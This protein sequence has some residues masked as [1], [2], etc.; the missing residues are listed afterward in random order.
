M[1]SLRESIKIVDF[2]LGSS[3]L[4]R[5][6][7]NSG[8]IP[9][10][11]LKSPRIPY[12]RGSFVP[13]DTWRKPSNQERKKI[14]SEH[15]LG[16]FSKSIGII[17]LPMHVIRP[18]QNAVLSLNTV[19][20]DELNNLMSPILDHLKSYEIYVGYNSTMS[21][22][23]SNPPNLSTVTFNGAEKC[24]IGLHLDS[25]DRMPLAKRAQST[26][27]ICI[28]I[29]QEDRYLLFINL[30]LMDMLEILRS[31]S[32]SLFE[33][34]RIKQ[35]IENMLGKKLIESKFTESMNPYHVGPLFMDSYSSYPVI[36]IRVSPGE[37]YIAPTENMI[38]DGSTLGKTF[39]D[40]HLTIRGYFWPKPLD[41]PEIDSS[42]A[43]DWSF[44]M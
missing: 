35:L 34:S 15:Y 29:G 8:V 5:F 31:K 36:K 1:L 39:L 26:N 17:R 37:A 16:D 11:K 13:K 23:A 20:S 24:Y 38:H 33:F 28:N 12:K 30:T 2:S 6:W 7:I 43:E 21:G 19:Q 10:S 18:L 14:F 25:W 32:R 4:P 22:I 9:C 41:C 42:N 3:E 27:R 40:R 44:A